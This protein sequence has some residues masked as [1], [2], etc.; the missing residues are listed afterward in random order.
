MNR[1]RFL[2]SA[3][4]TIAFAMGFVTRGV[5]AERHPEVRGALRAL[6]QAEGFLQRAD[7]DFS[8][9]R[10]KAVGLI[11]DAQK[12]LNEALASDR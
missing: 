1:K 5:T 10:T 7:R 12:E 6:A 3:T 9:H 8:G 2:A 11:H 4:V